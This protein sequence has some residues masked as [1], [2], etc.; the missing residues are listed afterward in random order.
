MAKTTIYMNNSQQ[1][2][3]VQDIELLFTIQEKH[4]CINSS[5]GTIRCD[6]SPL[7]ADTECP[8]TE[9]KNSIDFIFNPLQ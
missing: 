6:S 8:F 5:I 2:S 9:S 3:K 7:K 1:Q 4:L